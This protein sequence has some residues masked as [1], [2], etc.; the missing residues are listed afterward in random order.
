MPLLYWDKSI[1]EFFKNF[2]KGD[3]P[4][5]SI[6]EFIYTLY[7]IYLFE[8]VKEFFCSCLE[9]NLILM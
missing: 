1:I 2:I 7:G 8:Y 6:S 9:I 4:K 5:I 3:S